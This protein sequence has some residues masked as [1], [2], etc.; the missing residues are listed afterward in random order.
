MTT[1]HQYPST[2]K[3]LA[4]K[5]PT[6]P[7]VLQD[8]P[9]DSVLKWR[10]QEP[11]P[12]IHI[13][14]LRMGEYLFPRDCKLCTTRCCNDFR[15]LNAWEKFLERFT[16]KMSG[17]FLRLLWCVG[18]SYRMYLCRTSKSPGAAQVGISDLLKIREL[19][20]FQGWDTIIVWIVVV[21]L[22][23][24]GVH[25][26]HIIWQMVVMIDNEAGQ[27]SLTIRDATTEERL[28]LR[29]VYVRFSTFVARYSQSSRGFIDNINVG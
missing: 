13:V 21:P 1:T 9:A 17:M 26:Y 10:I 8:P 14:I 27:R 4:T 24:F 18:V 29:K 15:N 5:R 25:E 12:N 7:G 22:I 20:V 19:N 28:R 6:V 11:S 23:S 3:L 16:V 2:P